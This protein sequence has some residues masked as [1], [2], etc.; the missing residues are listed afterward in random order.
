MV[1][2]SITT[3]VNANVHEPFAGVSRSHSSTSSSNRIVIVELS[4]GSG[5]VKQKSVP[6]RA[7]N[8]LLFLKVAPIVQRGV[9]K[10]NERGNQLRNNTHGL[11]YS[12]LPQ[13]EHRNA[14]MIC[15]I[16]LHTATFTTEAQLER[17]SHSLLLIETNKQNF[18]DLD[19]YRGLLPG[20]VLKAPRCAIYFGISVPCFAVSKLA[21]VKTRS[22]R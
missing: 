5:Y 16:S 10:R 1:S 9:S 22:L 6:F 19:E 20:F 3:I 18:S 2:L 4:S 12:N 7:G 17:D 21:L 11:P 13:V 14:G 15:Q 8:S